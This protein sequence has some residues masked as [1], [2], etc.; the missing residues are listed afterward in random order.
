MKK[1]LPLMLF[2]ITVLF[3]ACQKDTPDEPEAISITHVLIGESAH[4]IVGQAITLNPTIIPSDATNKTIT[5]RSTDKDVASVNAE[6]VITGLKTGK[7]TIILTSVNE[8]ATGKCEITVKSYTY[9]VTEVSIEETIL[10]PTNTPLP[11]VA[12]IVPTYANNPAVTWKSSNDAIVSVTS[13]GIMTGK[14]EGKAT[15]TVTTVDGNLTDECEVTV[16]VPATT[17]DF[18]Y[19]DDT[20]S[21]NL[22]PEKTCIGI[23]CV[24]EWELEEKQRVVISLDEANLPWGPAKSVYLYNIDDGIANMNK[25]KTIPGWENDY[26]AFKWCDDKAKKS[27]K[28]WYLPA[29]NELF[30]FFWYLDIINKS[31]TRYGQSAP[32]VDKPIYWSSSERDSQNAHAFIVN[33][34]SNDHLKN[35]PKGYVRAVLVF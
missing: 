23:V 15:I 30:G 28:N 29:I 22:N 4:I 31:I 7:T 21:T 17:G 1:I 2:L 6:G 27:G 24:N 12:N 25:I 16:Y 20:Y 26:P 14:K 9:P 19:D 10:L 8:T 5:F 33:S 11:I 18:Y 3:T 32:L 34:D 35:D 13:D